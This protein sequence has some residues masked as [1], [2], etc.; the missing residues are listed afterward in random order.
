MLD[1]SS[2]VSSFSRIVFSELTMRRVAIVG[3]VETQGMMA[4]GF[5]LRGLMALKQDESENEV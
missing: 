1:F 3:D 5:F 2:A 4:E